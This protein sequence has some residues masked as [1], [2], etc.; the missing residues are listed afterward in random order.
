[1]CIRD[2]FGVRFMDVDAITNQWLNDYEEKLFFQ[3][4]EE[5]YQTIAKTDMQAPS[6][7]REI[8]LNNMRVSLPLP[9]LFSLH[10]SSDYVERPD[11]PSNRTLVLYDNAG[12][13]F[14]AGADS[15]ATPGTKH[16]VHAE[17]ILFLF[18]PTE[19]PRFRSILSRDSSSAQSSAKTHRQDILLIETIGRI[20]KYL[21]MSSNDRIRK[22]VIVGISKADLLPDYL[23]LAGDP[24]RVLPG[25]KDAALDMQVIKKMSSVVRSLLEK[26]APEIVATVESFAESVLYVP[27][28]ALGHH[29]SKAGIR[30]CDIKPRWVEVPLL[31]VLSRLGYVR[32]FDESQET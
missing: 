4:D 5:G 24:W 17:G 10:A 14:Q 23:P 26:F 30:P 9:S 29:P 31:Y 12:E 22:T 19:D 20:R 1:M 8:K 3:V 25:S 13:H 28:S 15:A 18:D 11:I 16:L 2:R 6:V 32:V 27:N 21:G 7:Y